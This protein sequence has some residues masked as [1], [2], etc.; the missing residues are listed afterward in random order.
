MNKVELIIPSNA[1]DDGSDMDNQMQK[2]D[3]GLRRMI[4]KG[5]ERFRLPENTEYYSAEQ[6]KIAEKK[7]IKYCIIEGRC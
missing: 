7:F 5:R 2:K 3:V 6:Y 4:E 1:Y